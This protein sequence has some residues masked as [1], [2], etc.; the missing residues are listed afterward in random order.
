MLLS[1][2]LLV[3]YIAF[4]SFW[5][6]TPIISRTRCMLLSFPNRSLYALCNFT[7]FIIWNRLL[8]S[9]SAKLEAH[10][11]T[12]FENLQSVF[13]LCICIITN[14]WLQA[15]EDPPHAYVQTFVLK[16]LDNSFFCQ[17]DIFRLGIHDTQW[18]KDSAGSRISAAW[19][20]MARSNSIEKN[21]W[22]LFHRRELFLSSSTQCLPLFRY[23]CFYTKLLTPWRREVLRINKFNNNFTMSFVN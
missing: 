19:W 10:R 2:P 3:I 7:T 23:H 16:P 21:K 14:L 8:H 15:D 5:H 11:Y 20:T 6:F 4:T 17:H 13:L 18:T 9:S 12:I 1:W 22:A